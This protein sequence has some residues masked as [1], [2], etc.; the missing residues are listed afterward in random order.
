MR[1]KKWMMIKRVGHPWLGG[2][3][4][5]RWS[6]GQSVLCSALGPIASVTAKPLSPELPISCIYMHY[7]KE[8]YYIGLLKDLAVLFCRYENEGQL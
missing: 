6:G 4:G 7:F 2:R 3:W 1:M 5:V 8:Y